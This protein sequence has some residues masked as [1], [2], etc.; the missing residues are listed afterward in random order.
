[1]G[2]PIEPIFE[3]KLLKVALDIRELGAALWREMESFAEALEGD[4]ETDEDVIQ[5]LI[6]YRWDKIS[7]FLIEFRFLSDG[8]V[9]THEEA[10]IVIAVERSLAAGIF[11]SVS[12]LASTLKVPFSTVLRKVNSLEDKGY[13]I[14]I[15][16]KLDN[17]K[18]KIGITDAGQDLVNHMRESADTLFRQLSAFSRQAS[19]L[20]TMEGTRG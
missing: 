20:E 15:D 11:L 3:P 6:Q 4:D 17:R 18:V 10:D 8:T 19:R 16:D 13:L 2:E 5:S 7:R 12:Q 9:L 14:R 1:M